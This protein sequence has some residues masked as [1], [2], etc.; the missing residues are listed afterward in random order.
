MG[1]RPQPRA[2]PATARVS[3]AQAREPD[4]LCNAD[5]GPRG[6]TCARVRSARETRTFLE[7]GPTKDLP[8]GQGFD[9]RR[10]DSMALARLVPGWSRCAALFAILI[11]LVA[12]ACSDA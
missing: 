1:C 12:S 8:S 5:A 7:L 6:G 2:L 10:G 3:G 11:A 9:P 4:G